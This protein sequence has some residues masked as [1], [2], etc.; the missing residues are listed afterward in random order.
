[1]TRG[2]AEASGTNL[3]AALRDLATALAASDRERSRDAKMRATRQVLVRHCVALLGIELLGQPSVAAIIKLAAESPTRPARRFC[4]VLMV[5][6]LAMPGLVPPGSFGTVCALV[7]GGLYDVLLRCGYPFG[8][9]IEQKMHVLERL[10]ATI[11]EL[12]QPLEPTFPNWQG[13]YAG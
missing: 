1:M 10:H 11:G 3:E 12:M 4:A 5:H 6:A 9:S 8:G 13:L 7:E 2:G